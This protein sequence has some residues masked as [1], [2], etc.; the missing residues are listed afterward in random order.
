MRVN[1]VLDPA[2]P[3][4]GALTILGGLI[5]AGTLGYLLLVPAPT[6]K[7]ITKNKLLKE[8]GIQN[9]ITEA[10]AIEAKTDALFARRKSAA[11]AEAIGPSAL[12][13]MTKLAKANG[14]SLVAFRPQRRIESPSGIEIFPYQVAIEGKYPQATKFVQAIER[15]MGDLAVT[16]YQVASASEGDGVAATVTILAM[17]DSDIKPAPPVRPATPPAGGAKPNG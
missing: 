10:K 1:A 7:G 16:G 14:L 17:R 15:T 6:T 4:P 8:R 11:S 13:R 9:K 12:S 3:V 5:L 2:D